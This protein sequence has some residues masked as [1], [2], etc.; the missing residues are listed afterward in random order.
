MP[1]FKFSLL[2]ALLFSF[3]RVHAGEV[4]DKVLNS[5][6]P[7]SLLRQEVW[8]L[9]AGLKAAGVRAV[10][11]G[12]ESV[13]YFAL[14]K[15]DITGGEIHTGIFPPG[16]SVPIEYYVRTDSETWV[17][18]GKKKYSSPFVAA[19]V[20]PRSRSTGHFSKP[21]VL[22][23]WPVDELNVLLPAVF[24]SAGEMVWAMIYRR[25][26]KM[27]PSPNLRRLSSGE[28]AIVSQMTPSM[29]ML[30]DPK[31]G[32]PT[33]EVEVPGE[34]LHHSFDFVENTQDF[35]VL[36]YDCRKVGYWDETAPVFRGLSGIFNYLTLPRRSYAGGKLLRV[37]MVTGRI[38]QIWSTY[39]SFSVDQN[40]NLA[41]LSYTDRFQDARTPAEYKAIL[42]D[43]MYT[44]AELGFNCDT[45]W[46]HENA[47]RY[48]PGKGY[49]ISIRNLNR[50][51]LI[52]ENGKLK[53]SMGNGPEN[54]YSVGYN[55]QSIG[56]THDAQLIEGDRLMLFDNQGF[57]RGYPE[58]DVRKSKVKIFELDG[59]RAH[60]AWEK[61]LP[62]PQATIRGS[63][64]IV[65]PGTVF[66]TMA[67]EGNEPARFMEFDMREA[68]SHA[69][70]RI[71]PNS[72]ARAVSARP[73][74]AIAD[75]TF[76]GGEQDT[77]FKFS[78][79]KLPPLEKLS[80]MD[81]RGEAY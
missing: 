73:I 10:I 42:R 14:K 13:G 66:V 43:P 37:N 29:V 48:Y 58:A 31:T 68:K 1:G 33:R 67:G 12:N 53:W 30:V 57:F 65:R 74:D 34:S 35:V 18:L 56:L 44:K 47:V 72:V 15:P 9:P 52:D 7:E 3:A 60:L 19:G 36:S 5:N 61:A 39:D 75:E 2:M 41:L 77:D 80:G 69:A 46:S 51:I 4:G 49:L 20:Q 32:K 23:G 6:W 78:D 22:V 25:D 45:D 27:I 11:Y 64:D 71:Q 38:H 40:P 8:S 59:T 24:N 76:L 70:M 21:F 79:I 17:K 81:S 50:V 63:V 55:G 16:Y 28:Y 26:G 62:L 54:R